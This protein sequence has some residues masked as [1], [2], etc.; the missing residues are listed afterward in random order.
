MTWLPDRKI[1]AAPFVYPQTILSAAFDSAARK[2][3]KFISAHSG[4]GLASGRIVGNMASE[5]QG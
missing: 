4:D 1:S 5:E 2:N 3:R